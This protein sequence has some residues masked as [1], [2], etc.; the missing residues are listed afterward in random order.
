MVTK[1]AC[2]AG[3]SAA[4]ATCRACPGQAS[5]HSRHGDALLSPL[6]PPLPGQ[7]SASPGV[8]DRDLCGGVSEK[9]QFQVQLVATVV[10]KNQG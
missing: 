7:W 10:N 1:E 8:N 5:G 2:V 9:Q 4:E 3:S 6:P